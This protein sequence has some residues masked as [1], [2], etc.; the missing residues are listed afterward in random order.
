MKNI[1]QAKVFPESIGWVKASPFDEITRR[2]TKLRL[3][4]VG[5]GA[6]VIAT[7]GLVDGGERSDR[8]RFVFHL[9]THWSLLSILE[10]VHG[11]SPREFNLLKEYK[12]LDR[13]TNTMN[14]LF[15]Y[16][17]RQDAFILIHT[18]FVKFIPR[19]R[20]F[21]QWAGSIL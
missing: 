1:L 2:Y 18:V 8:I 15:Y 19:P 13:L 6:E 14:F 4:V 9:Q 11:M 16:T 20:G 3:A 5:V 10:I 7:G 21:D 17:P 12:K